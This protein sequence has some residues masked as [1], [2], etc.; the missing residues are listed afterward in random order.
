MKIL[1]ESFSFIEKTRKGVDDLFAR[2]LFLGRE[3]NEQE[4]I[5]V[6]FREKSA[7]SI[8]IIIPEELSGPVSEGD[9]I[10]SCISHLESLGLYASASLQETWTLH[11]SPKKMREI[12]ISTDKKTLQV[13]A[14]FLPQYHTQDPDIATKIGNLSGFPKTAVAAFAQALREDNF[15]ENGPLL[16]N[17]EVDEIRKN[18]LY[19][20]AVLFAGFRLSRAHWKN[21]LKTV[22]RRIKTLKRYNEIFYRRLLDLYRESVRT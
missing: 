20:E 22:R 2:F 19:E 12:F 21:E 7:G 15:T 11:E 14:E 8:D 17:E 6:L 5:L 10:N 13:A 4:L 9:Y 1:P 18:P 16:T 3:L